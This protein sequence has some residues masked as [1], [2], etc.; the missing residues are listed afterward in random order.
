MNEIGYQGNELR[1]SQNIDPKATAVTKSRYNRIAPVYDMMETFME[2]FLFHNWR[3]LLWQNLNS[4]KDILEIGV[5]TGKNMPYYPK[6]SKITAIDLSDRMLGLAQKRAEVLNIKNVDLFL[7]DAQALEFQDDSF[8]VVVTT[9]VFCSVPNP[10]LGF[11][12]IK[13]ILRPNGKAVFL[14]HMY[15]ETR[16]L[17]GIFSLLNPLV[18]RLSGANIDRPTISNIHKAGLEIQ[19]VRN[20]TPYGIFRLIIAKLRK[21]GF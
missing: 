3:K 12:E 17:G 1:K 15:P 7:M 9:F 11:C 14:E 5:G 13:R 20:L 18:V 19:N 16:F 2:R 21:E 4:P 10:V 6:G 8:D